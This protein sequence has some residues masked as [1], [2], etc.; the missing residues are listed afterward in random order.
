MLAC[1]ASWLGTLMAF[2]GILGHDTF[3]LNDGGRHNDWPF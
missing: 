2:G 1:L 3:D